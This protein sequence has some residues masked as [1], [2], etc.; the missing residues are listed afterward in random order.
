MCVESPEHD[1][2]DGEGRRTALPAL[3]ADPTGTYPANC[4]SFDQLGIRVPFIACVSPFSKPGYVSH[5]VG[6]HTSVLA[7]IEKRFLSVGDGEQRGE[8][9]GTML[10]TFT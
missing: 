5:T 6:D 3:A 4:A 10:N 1:G 7:L 2:H 8:N 9:E